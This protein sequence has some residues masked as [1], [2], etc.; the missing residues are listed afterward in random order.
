MGKTAS[1][2]FIVL[3]IFAVIGIGGCSVVLSGYNG[4]ISARNASDRQF[5]NLE[6]VIQ[7]RS[8][9]VP[10]LVSVVKGNA[11][12]EKATL[13]SVTQARTAATQIKL[14]ADDLS[15]PAKMQ[16]F[17]EAQ[18]QLKGALSRLLATVEN[19][20]EL[21]ATQGFI[22]LQAQL[23]GTE[24]RINEERMKYNAS[25]QALNN[26]LQLFPSSIGAGFAGIAPRRPFEAS[27]SA[28]AVPEVKF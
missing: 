7:R 28:H 16:R 3:G 11:N 14:T 15:D 9:L 8:D 18:D 26:A 24:N 13:E 23:E 17:M 2:L 27:E 10:Q 12:Y 20:P 25:V 1:V 4:A 5:A 19:Y 22:E 21:K 6:S